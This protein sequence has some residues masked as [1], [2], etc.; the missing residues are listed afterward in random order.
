MK[1]QYL[2][3]IHGLP[4]L[5]I[6]DMENLGSC[7]YFIFEPRWNILLYV[8]QTKNLKKRKR[9]HEQHFDDLAF[10]LRVLDRDELVFRAI[11]VAQG[12]LNE[13]ERYYI[14]RY[15]PFM[16]TEYNSVES[17]NAY[18]L[19]Y[20]ENTTAGMK[21]FGLEAEYSLEDMTRE[22]QSGVHWATRGAT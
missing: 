16:N 7:V 1:K 15:Q 10:M 12:D 17:V 3:P 18:R 22:Y 8:G 13:V 20:A 5:T 4:E 11:P 2:F 21:H 19:W 9:G 14:R 6:S